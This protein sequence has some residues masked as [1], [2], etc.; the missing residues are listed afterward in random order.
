MTSSGAVSY[1]HSFVINVL[2]L[3]GADKLQRDADDLGYFISN[4]C[5][6]FPIP[7]WLWVGMGTVVAF[8]VSLPSFTLASIWAE[9]PG[10]VEGRTDVGTH[11]V[12]HF[13]C[14]W[15]P[16]T[17]RGL[18]FWS[19]SPS[20]KRLPSS[21]SSAIHIAREGSLGHT[22]LIFSTTV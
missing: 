15:V 18:H 2:A 5:L 6:S 9:L 11:A 7:R 14:V 3:E 10:G 19:K 13:S 20:S 12:S 16:S 4:V 1:D 21:P 17:P 22:F 8:S